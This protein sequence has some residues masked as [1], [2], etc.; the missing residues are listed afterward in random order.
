MKRKSTPEKISNVIPVETWKKVPNCK[1][2]SRKLFLNLK[3]LLERLLG[4]QATIHSP[5]QML[6]MT[7]IPIDPLPTTS[8]KALS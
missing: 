2:Q 8:Q 1:H 3:E 5:A 4:L 6:T 7:L